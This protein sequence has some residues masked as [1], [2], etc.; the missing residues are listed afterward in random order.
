QLM[1]PLG[2]DQLD[3]A[4]FPTVLDRFELQH[5]ARF[6][7]EAALPGAGFEV[8]SVLADATG[9]LS[10]FLPHGEG[11]PLERLR[12]RAAGLRRGPPPPRATRVAPWRCRPEPAPPPT[13]R[14]PCT[15]AWPSPTRPS[16]GPSPPGSARPVPA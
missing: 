15:C 16:A 1:V 4:T 5:A 9:E 12:R 7:P 2:D 14:A 11:R 3:A 10:G 6:G 8:L 13:A